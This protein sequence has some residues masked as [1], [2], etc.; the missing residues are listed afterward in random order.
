MNLWQEPGSYEIGVLKR[1]E[2]WR[3]APDCT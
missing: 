1:K 2:K 3:L